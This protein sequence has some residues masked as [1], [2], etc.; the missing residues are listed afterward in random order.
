M[1]P[2][3]GLAA[4]QIDDASKFRLLADGHLQAGPFELALK[5]TSH[6]GSDFSVLRRI[7]QVLDR[8]EV[9]QWH[10]GHMGPLTP[11]DVLAYLE[12]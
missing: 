12:R 9:V 3:E 5:F 10:P 6:T 2:G 1:L 7:R 8:E 11:D 4:H